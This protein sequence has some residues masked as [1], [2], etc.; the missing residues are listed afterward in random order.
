M[1]TEI[2]NIFSHRIRNFWI[3]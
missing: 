1:Q 3:N 2:T